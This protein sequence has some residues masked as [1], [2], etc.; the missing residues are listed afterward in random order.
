MPGGVDPALLAGGI[1]EVRDWPEDDA[2][3]RTRR[4]EH[5]LREGRPLLLERGE[6]DL[7]CLE[8]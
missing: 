6:A 5:L 3:R 7:V 1:V 2:V 4:V 8:G